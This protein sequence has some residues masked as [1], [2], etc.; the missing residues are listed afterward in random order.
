MMK[1]TSTKPWGC[2]DYDHEAFKYLQIPNLVSDEFLQTDQTPF[3]PMF[4]NVREFLRLHWKTQIL[5][6]NFFLKNKQLAVS[7][8]D[9]ILASCVWS[10]CWFA[11]TQGVQE[12]SEQ[13]QG[14]CDCSLPL[15]TRGCQGSGSPAELG[16]GSAHIVPVSRWA[17]TTDELLEC[18]IRPY[19]FPKVQGIKQC[20]LGQLT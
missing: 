20:R 6:F 7:L 2:P 3:L 8:L 1:S 17:G 5:I 18:G 9:Q 13:G 11:P 16:T 12:Q 4:K 15:R 19:L 14:S 10:Y